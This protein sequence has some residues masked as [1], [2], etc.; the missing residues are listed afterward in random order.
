MTALA[1]LAITETLYYCFFAAFYTAAVLLVLLLLVS[2]AALWVGWQSFWQ[3]C[4]ASASFA[5]VL[6]AA[7]IPANIVFVAALRNRY[8]VTADP[9]VDWLPW[10]PSGDWV[11]DIGCGGHYLRGASAVT[12]RIAWAALAIPTWLAS[13]WL[14]KRLHAGA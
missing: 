9:I 5:A 4:R 8:Y 11:L 14:Y 1:R 3:F 2:P 10:A 13:I 7:G 6:V 12:L